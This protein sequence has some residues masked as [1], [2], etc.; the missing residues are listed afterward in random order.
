MNNNNTNSP[1]PCTAGCGFFG[2]ESFNNMCSKC[3]KAKTPEDTA[4]VDKLPTMDK[5]PSIDKLPIKDKLPMDKLPTIDNLPSIDKSRK[6]VRSPSPDNPRSA[7]A[8]VV[9]TTDITPEKPVQTNKGRCFNC[10]I[11]VIPLC[12]FL[13]M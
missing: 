1:V 6:H 8:P 5:L 4:I 3:Y 2:S 10:R 11:K 12:G 13:Y 9:P 7:P